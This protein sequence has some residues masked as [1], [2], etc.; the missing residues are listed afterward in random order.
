MNH[1]A[2]LCH[3]PK[4]AHLSVQLK[5]YCHFFFYCIRRHNRSRCFTM[6]LRRHTR[7]QLPDMI[8]NRFDRKRLPNHTR[9]CHKYFFRRNFQLVCRK[10]AHIP[11]FLLS[12]RIARIR[13]FTI[14]NNSSGLPAGRVQIFLC[15]QD[16][17]SLYFIRRIYGRCMTEILAV[18]NPQIIL[19]G[20]VVQTA[21]TAVCC[22][23][24]SRADASLYIFIPCFL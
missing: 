5:R 13:I 15:H 14:Y 24:Q 4:P 1:P 2:S 9:R 7:Y 12:V 18:N 3:A 21:M 10:L 20:I 11:R 16:R 6:I 22:K 19:F 8:R 17:R 23:S